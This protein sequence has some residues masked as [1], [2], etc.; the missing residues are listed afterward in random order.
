M[1]NIFFALQP[2]FLWGKAYKTHFFERD[3]LKFCITAKN[4]TK[5]KFFEL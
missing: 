4:Q 5:G 2:T 3:F 1:R